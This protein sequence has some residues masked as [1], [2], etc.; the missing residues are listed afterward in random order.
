[1]SSFRISWMGS[2]AILCSAEY[3][4]LCCT[5]HGISDER[6]QSTIEKIMHIFTFVII[7]IDY[8]EDLDKK[9]NIELD[10]VRDELILLMH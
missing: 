5:L 9:H 10:I 2:F 4:V 8:K 7:T 3:M 6:L 1:M